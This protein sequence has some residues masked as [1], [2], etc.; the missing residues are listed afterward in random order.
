MREY[1]LKSPPGHAGRGYIRLLF[2][3]GYA[4]LFLSSGT[5]C[6]GD[7][8]KEFRI[9]LLAPIT[10]NIPT[11]GEST[12]NAANLVVDQIN[13]AGGL[14]VAGE[15]YKVVLLVEDNEDNSDVSASKV[16]ALI[17]NLEVAAI[18]GP[19]ASRNAIPASI[20]AERARIP[21][22]SPS[23]TNPETTLNKGWVFRAAFI[24]PFQGRV[25]ARFVREQL[26]AKTVA[27]I[28]DVGS[29]YNRDLAEVF[30]SSFEGLGGELVAF[31][32]YT[33]D[34]PD[35]TPQLSRV[36]DSGAEVLFL[37]NYS[38]EVVEQARQAREVGVNA[39]LIG[40]DSWGTILES[41]RQDLD[42][43]YF[44]THYASDSTDQDA[45]Q[46]ITGYREAFGKDPDDV[47]ALTFDSF[48]LLFEAASGQGKVDS[49]SIRAG[50]AS[51]RNYRGV[52]GLF[53][54]DGLSG[55]PVKSVFLMKIE[56]GEFVLDSRVEP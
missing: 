56:N 9:G 44:S 48:G 22:I 39:R 24:D 40:S 14:E 46:F 35:I 43:A 11:V 10:G 30:T 1:L 41:D 13:E 55:D 34:S 29:I 47:A 6:G 16:R 53:Q 26:H 36:K 32:S 4:L 42:G 18:V 23:S 38:L 20:V 52:T 3:I 21:M 15:K 2:A 27:V 8:Q 12:V 19:Q 31:E 5:A 25:L 28:F 7:Q 45:Q 49:A 50:L 17:G 51:I 33:S 54:F 37:P